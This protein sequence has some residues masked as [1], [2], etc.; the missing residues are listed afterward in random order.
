MK[1]DWKIELHYLLIG[2][3]VLVLIG[4]LIFIVEYLNNYDSLVTLGSYIYIILTILVV[5]WLMGRLFKSNFGGDK[6]K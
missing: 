5:A 3:I 4:F 1:E 6:L 2:F